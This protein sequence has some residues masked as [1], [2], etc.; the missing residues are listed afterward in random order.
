MFSVFSKK[1]VTNVKWLVAE[2][3]TQV[4]LGI[5][6]IPKLFNEL[7]TN[8]IGQLAFSKSLIGM[9][10]P[11]FFLGLSAICIRELVLNPLE[12]HKILATAFYLRLLSCIVVF[13]GLS[14]YVSTA[15]IAAIP[16]ILLIIGFGYCLKITDVL[17]YYL[18]AKKQSKTLFISRISSLLLITGAQYWGIQEHYNVYYFAKL[19]AVDFLIQGAIY[20]YFLFGKNELQI[21][22]WKFSKTMAIRLLKSSYPLIISNF[23]ILFYIGID[24]LFIK[25]YLGDTE[26]GIFATVQFLVIALTWN[27]GFA[28]INALYPAFAEA[29]KSNYNLYLKRLRLTYKTMVII[30]V[31]IGFIFTFFSEFILTTFYTKNYFTA[32]IPLKIF[33]WAP[34]FIFIGMIYEK[35]LVNTNQL[36]KDVYRFTI[37]CIVNVVL[38]YY[39]I[40]IYQVKGAAIAVLISHFITNIGYLFIDSDGRKHLLKMIG[41]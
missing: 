9:V 13:T 31:F 20:S 16:F 26:N 5:F 41:K 25:Y 18:H 39:L 37:G 15:K 30:G 7:G 19:I 17:E 36:Q 40:P 38:C 27:I 14:I 29:Y 35:H 10:T 6:I 24:E 4:L 3:L 23:I 21:T 32:N 11:L 34:L 22:K 12:K 8:S 33:G 28:I 1:D 2:K